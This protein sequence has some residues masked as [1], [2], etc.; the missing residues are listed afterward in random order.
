MSV[1]HLASGD[2]WTWPEETWRGIVDRVRAGRSVKP[3]SWKGGATCAVALSFDSD[4]ET[5]ELRNGGKSFSRI[6]QGQ[7]GARARHSAHSENPRSSLRAGYFL[8]AGGV[9]HAQPG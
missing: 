6:S 9:G 8:H 7:Y 3:A 4:H 2:P 5:I 1:S